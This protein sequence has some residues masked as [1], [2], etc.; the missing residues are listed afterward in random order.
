M[1]GYESP[2]EL[3]NPAGRGRVVLVCEHAS[4]LVPRELNDLGLPRAEIERHIGWDIGALGLAMECARL[5]D[6]PLVYARYSRLVLDVNRPVDAPDS[7]VEKSEDTPI[8]GNRDLDPAERQR[9]RKTIYEPF[10][11]ALAQVIAS[12]RAADADLAVV[13]IHSFTPVYRGVARPWQIGVLSDSDRRLADGLLRELRREPGLV[14]GDNQP[15]S[16]R[17]RV[18]HTLDRHAQSQGLPSAMIEV[19]NDGLGSRAGQ[20]AWAQRLCRVL[21]AALPLVHNDPDQQARGAR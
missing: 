6:A 17:D 9:R 11:A 20:Q 5:L 1:N 15:Y 19:R 12:R 4:S 21:D 7:I 3:I 10:H 16:P 13:N 8:P 2:V 14:V 18:Y